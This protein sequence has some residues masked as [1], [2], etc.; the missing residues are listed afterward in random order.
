[1]GC[2]GEKGAIGISLSH[3]A[4]LEEKNCSVMGFTVVK[5]QLLNI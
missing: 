1:M 5:M 2:G 3:L 4:L